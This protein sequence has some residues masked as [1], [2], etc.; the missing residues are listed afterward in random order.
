[1]NKQI[2]RFIAAGIASVFMT[3]AAITAYAGT[4][5]VSTH[6]GAGYSAADNSEAAAGMGASWVRDEFTWRT[7][8]PSKGSMSIQPNHI[9][10]L[11]E[12]EGKGINT[13]MILAYGNNAYSTTKMPTTSETEYYNAWLNYVS[14]VVTQTKD[15]VDAWEVW[16]EPDLNGGTAAQY[17]QLYVDTRDVI[18]SID[19][20]STVV[21]GA[22]SAGSNWAYADATLAA[23]KTL[24]QNRG[25]TINALIDAFSIHSYAGDDPANYTNVLAYGSNEKG[26]EMHLDKYGYTGDVWMSETGISTYS[27]GKGEED[28]A[29]FGINMAIRFEK[30]LKDNGRGGKFIWYDLRNDGTDAGNR[31]HNF[32]L[33]DYYYTPKKAY[34][35]FS[36]YNRLVG[37]KSFVSATT[38]DSGSTYAD[39]TVRMSQF[40]GTSGKVYIWSK[41]TQTITL[42]GDCV[43]IYDYQ[44][45]VTETIT[46]PSGTKSIT[47]G[48]D[49][50]FVECRNYIV[51]LDSVSYDSDNGVMSVS[52]S[53]NNGGAITIELV[54]AGGNVVQTETA[55]VS[56]GVFSKWFSVD[57]AGNYT[58]R[59]GKPELTALGK[60]S[61]WQQRSCNVESTVTPKPALASGTVVS[62]NAQTRTITASG[63]VTN[64]A[65]NQSV[66]LLALP[67]T[68]SLTSVNPDSLAALIQSKITGGNFS[69]SCV[70]PDWYSGNTAVYISGTEIAEKQSSEI[71]VADN[72]YVYAAGFDASKTGNTVTAA[73]N[74]R[75]FAAET[76]NAAIII[77]K[78]AGGKVVGTSVQKLAVPAYTY[79]PVQITVSDT[80]SNDITN[81]Q[82]YLWE[83]TDGLYPLA[84]MLTVN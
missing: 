7:I 27:G 78:Y 20:D 6:V 63:S 80:V 72:D 66:T 57:A 54:D 58:V 32:G 36:L 1:M 59:V 17:A 51:T 40:S 70:L 45:R 47:A 29:R 84:P 8:E 23:I 74:I 30:Y 69:F 26:L 24:A 60:S 39:R 2:H 77:A 13:L 61:G 33:V 82:A 34:N 50:V 56:G 25:T 55:A 18:K 4:V 9:S 48:Y 83:D 12:L 10:Y 81:V 44:G 73:A 28:Q 79:T 53:Y 14:Y 21:C 75:N 62:Y 41:A 15:Y 76:K 46:N 16:N 42:S 3:G 43:Y 64:S 31:E 49:P 5:G 67:K 65:E 22:L 19:A 38:Y 68:Q 11:R 35:T 52:G 37:D 71:S